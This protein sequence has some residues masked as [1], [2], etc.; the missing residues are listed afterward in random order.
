MGGRKDAQSDEGEES[1]PGLRAA[2][3][4]ETRLLVAWQR[5]GRLW[6]PGL[7]GATGGS[8]AR[9]PRRQRC[10]RR[11]RN[12]WPVGH[13]GGPETTGRALHGV[14]PDYG[15]KQTDRSG[16]LA[17]GGSNQTRDRLARH[18]VF[19][20][21]TPSSSPARSPLRMPAGFS[22]AS[23]ASLDLASSEDKR[24]G[25][26]DEASSSEPSRNT[27]QL[28]LAVRNVNLHAN[29]RQVARIDTVGPRPAAPLKTRT[30]SSHA[31]PSRDA[32]QGARCSAARGGL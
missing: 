26:R 29:A 32:F 27:S 9:L 20:V 5:R 11:H 25:G 10:S 23:T 3:R 22:D 31:A 21:R 8:S 18:R 30:R 24:I 16:G 19:A 14:A 12:S 4:R 17:T 2:H 13:P 15:V 6:A 7:A 1:E 28:P